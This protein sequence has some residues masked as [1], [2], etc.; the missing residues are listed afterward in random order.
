M[1]HDLQ[2]LAFTAASLGFV[3]TIVG[4]DHYVPF[5]VMAKS[6][7]WS[8][9]KTGWIT[10]FCG[11][12]HIMS[13]ILLG[14][15]G[16]ALGIA[17]HRLEA[18]ESFRGNLAGW[19]LIAFGLVYMVWGIRRAIRNRPHSHFHVH[20]D[21][22][23]HEHDHGHHD[24]HSHVHSSAAKPKLTPWILFTIFVFG[25]CEPLIPILMYPAAQQSTFGLIMVA[26]IFGI[27]T[28]GTM[29]TIVA[30]SYL[31]IGILPQQK[32]ERYT[33]ALAGATIFLCGASIQI[34]GL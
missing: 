24:E 32:L 11:L 16:V 5:I 22:A 34:L 17:V 20:A 10:F 25:P 15:I 23:G 28:I 19:T 8:L 26:A 13:S 21:G 18:V 14:L 6:Q 7:K 31:G 33:H 27:A 30:L 3:H 2:I 29:M 9:A 1:T 4:P 12:G